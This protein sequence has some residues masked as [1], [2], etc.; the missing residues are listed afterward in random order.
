MI[1]NG[2]D[3]TKNP[4]QYEYFVMASA[5]VVGKVPYRKLAFGGAIRG[6]KTYVSLGLQA[7]FA[8]RF[9]GSKHH[10]I[11][12]DFPALQATSIPS[13]EKIL[14][15][16]PN[17]KWNRDKSNFFAY[18]KNDSKIFFKAEN[19]K[20][21]P[22]LHDFLGLETN[23]IL[24]EQLE[25]LQPKTLQ[26]ST[27]RVGSWYIDPMPTG[28]IFMTFNPTQKWP[29]KEIYLK[30]LNGEL[31]PD[32]FYMNA[33]P[34]DNAFVTEEQWA[35]WNTMDER[36]QRQYIQGDWTD[37]DETDNR[38]CYCY[39]EALHVGKVEINPKHEIILSFDFNVDPITCLVS[40]H[41]NGCLY[42]LEQI[43]LGNSNI[44]SLC[45]YID[46][47]YPKKLF[48]VTGDASGENRSAMVKDNLNYY[49]I[50]RTQLG[51]NAL[52][53]KVPK[54][55]PPLD[56]NRLLVNSVLHKY[57][58]VIDKDLCKPL[59]RDMESVRV[60]PDGG[61][62]KTDKTLTHALDCF[63]YTCNTFLKFVLIK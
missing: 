35:N 47:K 44:Y 9:P 19:Y 7:R 53:F 30:H 55:N 41:Y 14:R 17:W 23:T 54:S 45:E 15:G 12:N 2:I 50:I 16:S 59:I 25:E 58:V 32:F 1:L 39:N 6:G 10:V 34:S 22:E 42:C 56:E 31:P 24:L 63:R 4:K 3:L 61:I 20:Q 28:L 11:R 18:H 8:G 38:F 60:L 36:Y 40:Q 57:K 43:K 62:D 51:I 26:I 21:D 37:F 5:A 49:K 48:I 52:A 46:S 13:L 29:K 33:L 27:S